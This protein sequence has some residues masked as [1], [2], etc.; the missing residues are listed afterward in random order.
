MVLGELNIE[1]IEEPCPIFKDY[2]EL[3]LS[4]P[5]DLKSDRLK[6]G[7]AAVVEG[8]QGQKQIKDGGL[9]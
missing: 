8:S 4:L 1:K 5:H 3:W 2:A 9:I 6:S 7:A